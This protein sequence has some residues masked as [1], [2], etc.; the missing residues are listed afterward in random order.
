MTIGTTI[1]STATLLGVLRDEQA[2]TPPSNY[3]L[4]LAFPNTV[5]FTDEYIDFS[6][7]TDQRKLAPLVVPT[8]QGR[9]IYSAAERL[10]RV[11]PAYVKPK[12][13]VSA[14]RMIQRAAGLGE[15]NTNTNWTPQQRYNA[16]VADIM[17]QHRR[18]I[19]RRWEWLAGQAI[20]YGSV[21]LE[22]EAY[23][24]TVI[25][26]ERDA[27]HS[28]TLG[29][30]AR[31]GDAGVSIVDNVESW[32]TL[33]RRAKFGGPSNRLTVGADAWEV[34]R[35]DTELRGLLGLDLR[36]SNNGLTM[37]L[38]V[39]EGLDVEKVG[40]INGTTEIYVY[41]DYYHAEDG[42]VTPFM[43]P[44]DV[45][46]TGPG[47]QGVRCFGA[48]EDTK[49]GF[50]P[51]SMFPKMWDNEDPSATFIMT[52]SAPLMVPV[53]PNVSLRARVVA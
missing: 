30:S 53:N 46:L 20:L 15:L 8:A 28:I 52:Q 38:G 18:A 35:A 33:M 25:D 49:A 3:W 29:A 9:P 4:N 24:T 47:I 43:D 41:S 7:L 36:T 11:K 22:G 17:R 21:T 50:Q 23:P 5:N 40:T 27:A 19:E 37:N 12:D 1:Y 26:F 34:M 48:I 10:S 45:V 51:L 44:R 14:S 6:K 39:R 16:I 13:A 31:W 32:K 2:M 42:S